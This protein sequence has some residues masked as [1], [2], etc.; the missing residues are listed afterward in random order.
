MTSGREYSDETARRIDEEI[1]RILHD[2]E[3]RAH[4]LLVQ[5][6]SGLDVVA[7]ELLEKETIDGTEVARLLQAT[8]GPHDRT[9]VPSPSPA[10]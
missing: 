7:E 5:H 1:A 8:M 3:Q 2:Q 9:E 10:G 6:R 4:E